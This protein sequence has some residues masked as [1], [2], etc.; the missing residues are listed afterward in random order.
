M[1]RYKKIKP[2]FETLQLTLAKK[3]ARLEKIAQTVWVFLM[4]FGILTIAVGGKYTLLVGIT[5]L[6]MGGACLMLGGFLFYTVQG[7]W[8][9]LL[10]QDEIAGTRVGPG[11]R[12]LAGTERRTLRVIES[13]VL[14][15]MG[16]GLLALGVLYLI[17]IL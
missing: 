2:E 1:S 5:A 9:P 14:L 8:L 10:P 16:A 12:E 4:I 11:E 17:G 6:L 15:M 7:G 13:A 3:R